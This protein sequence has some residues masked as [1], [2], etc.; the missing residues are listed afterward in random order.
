MDLRR[1]SPALTRQHKLEV[2]SIE[3]MMAQVRLRNASQSDR[4]Q[5]ADDIEAAYDFLTGRE[6]WLNGCCILNEEW[7]WYTSGPGCD[8]GFEIPLRPLVLDPAPTIEYLGTDGA[9]YAAVD[10]A[11]YVLTPADG[12]G[13]FR[14]RQG[15]HWPTFFLRDTA[16]YRIRFTAGF[17]ELQEDVPSPIRKAIRMLAA[18]WWMQRETTGEPG[19]AV[20]EDVKYGLKS[21]AGRYRLHLDHS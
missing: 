18:H 14:K 7:E 9:T 16:S 4:D 2:V 3:Q 20:G 21:L 1:I 10:P 8:L 11:I 13:F 12:I 15:K 6:G 17:G 19:R 5:L